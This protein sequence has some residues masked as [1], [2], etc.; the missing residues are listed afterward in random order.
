MEMLTNTVKFFEVP[1]LNW[2]IFADPRFYVFYQSG[3]LFSRIFARRVAVFWRHFDCIKQLSKFAL[4]FM[5]RI[6]RVPRRGQFCLQ[7]AQIW[8]HYYFQF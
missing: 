7:S 8:I 1:K 2:P 5:V 4:D 3:G 6:L